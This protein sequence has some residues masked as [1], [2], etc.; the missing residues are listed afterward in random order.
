MVRATFGLAGNDCH[1]G[2]PHTIMDSHVYILFS[3]TGSEPGESF[4]F[5]KSIRAMR[6]YLVALLMLWCRLAAQETQWYTATQ[7]DFRN[8]Y[9]L[10]EQGRYGAARDGFERLV[11]TCKE[12][13]LAYEAWLC[14][15]ARYYQA[16]C[17]SKLEHS[18]AE[19]LLLAVATEEEKSPLVRRAAWAL[20]ELY[21]Q[22]GLY[23]KALSWLK[24]V[25]ASDLSPEENDQFQFL[26][27]TSYFFQRDERNAKPL[28]ATLSKQ[29]AN[30]YH[31]LSNYYYGCLLYKEGQFAEAQRAFRIAE[32]VPAVAASAGMYLA[33]IALA[34]RRYDE[35][36]ALARNATA[37]PFDIEYLR[38]EATAWFG[39]KE[40]GKALPLW[41]QYARAVTKLTASELYQLGFAQYMNE[42]W[43][44]A[45]ATLSQLASLPDSLGQ[46]ALYLV[47]DAR[48][49]LG[50]REAARLAF[51]SAA[52]LS[53]DL[54]IQ[55]IA[56]YQYAKLSHQLRH[57]EAAIR[58]LKKYLSAYPQSA[59]ANE[60]QQYLINELA[61]TRNYKEALQWIRQVEPKNMDLRRI[62][63]RIALA[64]A[65]EMFQDRQFEKALQLLDESL[66]NPMDGSLVAAA[67]FW[68]GEAAYRLQRFQDALD[69]HQQFL[70]QPL[71]RLR[72]SEE[73][74]PVFSHYTMGYSYLKLHQYPQAM[75]QFDKVLQRW[76]TH[77]TADANILG[78]AR[79]RSGDCRFMVSDYDG[80]MNA[81]LW[82]VERRLPGSDYALFQT[83]MIK[84]LKNLRGEQITLLRQLIGQYEKSLYLPNAWY[85]L[86]IALL[87]VPSY[88][89]ALEAFQ[90]VAQRYPRHPLAVQARLQ[91]G[92]V[93]F[94]LDRDQEALEQYRWVLQRYPKTSEGQA[95]L[96]AVK[97]I[98]TDRG[99][100]Q[101]YMA[102]LASLP[103]VQVSEVAKDSVM[104]LSAESK[105]A[106][107]DCARAAAEFGSYLDQ[108]PA[109]MFVIPARFYRAE[110]LAR[111]GRFVEALVDYE[112]VAAQPASRYTEKALLQCARIYYTHVQ[113][114]RQALRYFDLLSQGAEFRNSILEASRGKMYSAWR[115]QEFA[116]V[117]EAVDQLLLLP[118]LAAE[119]RTEARFYG[120]LAAMALG[121]EARAFDDLQAVFQVS[122]TAMGAEAGYHLAQMYFRKNQLR[123]AEEQCWK[124]IRHKPAHDYW[125]AKSFL[126]LAAIF[127]Q[128]GDYFQAAATLQSIID[129]Y[130]GQDDIKPEALQRLEVVRS[131]QRAESRLLQSVDTDTLPIETEK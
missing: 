112:F 46:H 35:V 61:V 50:E 99:D 14:Q 91:I 63:Q 126:L 26:F 2:P 97:E 54:R 32:K 89:G 68:K 69:F 80:A 109:G 18:D 111:L 55:Q 128:E 81:Y 82:V 119:D 12:D 52:R 65:L 45:I 76:P 17:A 64:H 73:V 129:N 104:Y 4:N 44:Q 74:Q 51:E 57:H 24:K 28:L 33:N 100:A 118:A 70:A 108:F 95:A 84:G 125:V 23:A 36:I 94:N 58:S 53:Y 98:F 131:K 124:V 16:I 21:Y 78:D 114:Y 121:Q 37:G 88:Q 113:D 22:R 87:S 29:A 41:Q 49:R 93:F 27:A 127:E 92:L 79:L 71:E 5:T 1:C 40:Y 116:S 130:T 56:L 120:G 42:Q 123:K 106:K 10:F 110:C 9:L 34:Q 90:N 25:H 115:V 62:H 107:G 19:Q 96:R 75:T 85:E 122:A 8:A 20:G 39:K 11:R 7:A 67:Y 31:G 105:F 38:L 43:T 66:N 15:E 72:L 3:R 48:L 6:V 83:A 77:R 86:G 47:G 30:P 13:A 101:G 102:F 59:E 60:L 103:E 117:L